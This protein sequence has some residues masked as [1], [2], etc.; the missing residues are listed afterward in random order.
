MP[1]LDL[2]QAVYT[3]YP[4]RARTL[5]RRRIRATVLAPF[6]ADVGLLAE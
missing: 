5:L 1:V 3:T 4:D 6:D 2:V